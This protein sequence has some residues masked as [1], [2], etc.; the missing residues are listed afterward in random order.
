[1]ECTLKDIYVYVRI[2]CSFTVGH[3]RVLNDQYLLLLKGALRHA[4]P[5]GVPWDGLSP[6]PNRIG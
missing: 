6:F 3:M 4:G 1:M 2:Q 5:R